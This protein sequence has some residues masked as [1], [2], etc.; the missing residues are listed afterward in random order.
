MTLPQQSLGLRKEVEKVDGL[1]D[2]ASIRRSVQT[3]VSDTVILLVGYSFPRLFS[4]WT[5]S[6][7]LPRIGGLAK[8]RFG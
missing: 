5:E 3:L 2:L 7:N 4:H 8:I 1:Y 6:P